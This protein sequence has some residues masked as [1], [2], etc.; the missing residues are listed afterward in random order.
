[1]AGQAVITIRDRQWQVYLA[2]EPWELV[3]GLSG[4]SAISPGTGMLFVLP[5]ETQVTVTTVPLLFPI[6]IAFISNGIVVDIARNVP[7]GYLISSDV[8]VCYFLEVNA[9]ELEGIETGDRVNIELLPLQIF[10]NVPVAISSVVAFGAIALVMT[11]AMSLT[12]VFIGA[13]LGSREREMLPQTKSLKQ[14]LRQK[15]FDKGVEAGKKETWMNI[16]E[17]LPETLEAHRDRIRDAVDLVLT[18]I[19]LWEETDHF[20]T[21]YGSKMWEDAKADI[22]LYLELEGAFWLGYFTGRQK[23]GKDVFEEARKALE[24]PTEFLPQVIKKRQV[25]FIVNLESPKYI[26]EVELLDSR[27]VLK[28]YGWPIVFFYPT[29]TQRRKIERGRGILHIFSDQVR[30]IPKDREKTK[31]YLAA[32]I[33][34]SEWFCKNRRPITIPELN[35]ITTKYFGTEEELGDFYQYLASPQGLQEFR[36]ELRD[37][38]RRHGIPSH[39]EQEWLPLALGK[40]REQALVSKPA[41]IRTA[42]EQHKKGSIEYL[43]DSPEFLAQTIEAIGYRDRL[44]ETFR[45]A[46]RRAKETKW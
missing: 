11:L 39:H 33:E 7:P 24:T 8:P 2:T 13:A 35:T 43:A 27:A 6:D 37:A 20:N 17:T 15:W 19:E 1:M 45:E 14:N 12:K 3:Q 30:E 26:E 16:E 23:I 9:G 28:R 29:D 34:I 21:L 32:F 4:V 5:Y 44:D 42:P 41:V 25:L 36:R 18:D 46:I 10:D 22:D 31:K 38:M 40:K